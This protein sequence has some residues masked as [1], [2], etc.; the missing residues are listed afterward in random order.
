MFEKSI[1]VSQF[2]ARFAR[3]YMYRNIKF[4]SPIGIYKL[5]CFQ[6]SALPGPTIRFYLWT[7]LGQH[8]APII[9]SRL[10]CGPLAEALDPPVVTYF[11]LL[12]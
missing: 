12:P 5:K 4:C 2:L 11:Y 6:L 3:D 8:H 10:P 1:G 7:T 9:V